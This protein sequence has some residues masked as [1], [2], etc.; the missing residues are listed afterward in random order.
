MISGGTEWCAQKPCPCPVLRKY[1][2]PI[3]SQQ[4]Q[5][6]LSFT[7]LCFHQAWKV[8]QAGVMNELLDP[9][10]C[11][12]SQLKEIKR[13]VEIGLLCTQKKPADRPT[14]PVVLEMLNGKKKLPTPKLPGYIKHVLRGNDR[15]AAHTMDGRPSDVCHAS[16]VASPHKLSYHPPLMAYRS[17]L[18]G[19]R[20]HSI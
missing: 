6:N 15:N 3:I 7:M 8:H 2:C 20:S 18:H 11:D 5:L 19:N 17:L 1:P 14:M 12:Q 16:V 10:L 9:L 13:C 4:L